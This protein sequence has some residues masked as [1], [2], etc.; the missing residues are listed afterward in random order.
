M[1]RLV[2]SLL[3]Q[4]SSTLETR[5]GPF[6]V[7]RF[8]DLARR[9]PVLALHQGPLSGDAPVLARVHSAC[10]TS[11]LLQACD[12]DCANQLEA[13]LARIAERGRGVVFYLLQEGR[14]AGFLAKARDRMMVQA[15]RNRLTTF[16]AYARMGLPHD[17]RRYRE[18]IDLRGQLG[19]TAP[20][21][22]LTNNPDKVER[23]EQEKIPVAA[24]EPLRERPS[25]W[26]RHYLA[27][28][29][30]SGHALL[31]DDASLGDAL[32]PF[33]VEPRDPVPLADSGQIFGAQYGLAVRIAGR[34]EPAWLRCAVF[35]DRNDGAVRLRLSGRAG[36]T[37][38]I[39]T[40]ALTDRLPLAT[41]RNGR[42]AIAATIAR[43]AREGGT[44]LLLDADDARPSRRDA[45]AMLDAPAW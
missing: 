24:T 39:V 41:A 15:S 43:I 2:G 23:V 30:R 38:R 27:A 42:R 5:V 19:I 26:N 13:A 25:P 3:A 40:H 9:R 44:A 20:F 17:L 31:A 7:H 33:P 45:Q 21:V 22:L 34:D 8:L 6:R 4:A 28:K 11:E 18:V 36:D 32:P 37:R 1:S 35:V 12:C 10:I 29:G 16:E 14:G